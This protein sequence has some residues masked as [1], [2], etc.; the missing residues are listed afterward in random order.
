M[1]YGLQFTWLA[2]IAIVLLGIGYWSGLPGFLNFSPRGELSWVLQYMPLLATALLIPLAKCC[3][4]RWVLFWAVM[5]AVSSFQ[6]MILQEL[7]AV[8]NYSSVLAAG[9]MISGIAFPPLLLWA[10]DLEGRNSTVSFNG[11]TRRL[12]IFYLVSVGY[13]FSFHYVWLDFSSA[14]NNGEM[15]VPVIWVQVIAALTLTVYRWW[16]LGNTEN[17]PWQLHLSSTLVGATSL[18]MGLVAGGSVVV[19]NTSDYALIA[20]L[21]YNL[22][23]FAS[24][25]ALI[26]QGLK[27]G[28]RLSFWSG[29]ILLTLQILSRMLE[30]QTGLILKAVVLLLCGITI[31][32]AGLW[33]ERHLAN[34]SL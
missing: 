33:F 3:Q 24:A 15:T 4:S 1:A 32:L 25:I 2:M 26:R 27:Q 6:V 29:I 9:M 23:L 31:V 17:S 5:A 16:Q 22:I 8:L 10:S 34:S 21:L 12:S 18:V 14:N 11:V 20:T 30:Y 7:S 28:T 13:V 19:A